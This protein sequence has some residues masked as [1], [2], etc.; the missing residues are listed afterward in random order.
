MNPYFCCLSFL[1]LAGMPSSKCDEAIAL[2]CALSN[3]DNQ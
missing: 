2:Y 3:E 1:V